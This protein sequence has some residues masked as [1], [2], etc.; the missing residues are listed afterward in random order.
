MYRLTPT[1]NPKKDSILPKMYI[2]K[3]TNKTVI[4]PNANDALTVLQKTDI[5]VCAICYRED[6][7][8]SENDITWVE[9]SECGIWVVLR[10]Q[11]QPSA[12]RRVE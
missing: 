5:T 1:R 10:S 2:Y 3:Q 4:K 7:P 6:D 11:T 9:C 8:S 12:A